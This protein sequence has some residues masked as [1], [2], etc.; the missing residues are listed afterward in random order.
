[1]E[2]FQMEST[3]RLYDTVVKVLRQHENWLDRRHLGTLAWMM[4]GLIQSATVSLTAWVPYVKSRARYAQSTQRRF[5][6][7]LANQRIQVHG[8][9]APLIQQALICWGEHTL[10]LALDTTVLWGQFC[11][12]RLVLI[13]R[14]RAIPWVWK[15][16]EH[17]SATVGFS[18]YQPL[19]LQVPSL[20]PQGVKVV[21][22]A[23]RGFADTDLMAFIRTLGWHFRIRIKANF[24]VYQGKQGTQVAHFYL[25]PGQAMYL[26]QVHLTAQRYGPVHLALGYH[27]TNGEKWYVVSS[28]P[29]DGTTFIEYGLR[30]DIEENFLDDK[31]NGF[32]LEHSAI[33]TA[34]A[35]LKDLFCACHD[36]AFSGFHR[37][38]S[39]GSRKAS[40]GRPPLVSRC[41]LSSYRLAMGEG[42]TGE[43]LDA[44]Y[45]VGPHRWSGKRPRYGIDS[46]SGS[47][48]GQPSQ[49]Q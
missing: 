23:D 29:T 19:L 32:Q 11:V 33:R 3:P 16:L 15:V 20:L 18:D 25:R 37:Y 6:R 21:L 28:E 35:L 26:H 46:P 49:N 45:P 36:D 41:Q 10:Y 39:G 8:L 24:W 13:Y 22:L 12:I 27:A 42:G 31:S 17:K 4:V 48:P 44:L 2:V 1:M 43:G 40:M 5:A 7:W 38:T 14:G 34:D 9:Y 47:H 30:F